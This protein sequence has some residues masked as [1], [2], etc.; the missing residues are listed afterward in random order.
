MTTI[1][2]RFLAGRYHA[3]PWGNH[4]NEGT[5]EW[6]PSPWRLLRGLAASWFQTV[7][8][9][10]GSAQDEAACGTLLARLSKPP[11]LCLPAVTHGHTRQ[12]MPWFKNWNKMKSDAKTLVFDSFRVFEP[13]ATLLIGWPDLELRNDE[14]SLLEQLL[15]GLSYLGRAESW[16]Q[17]ELVNG[18]PGGAMESAGGKR[19]MNAEA[20][21]NTSEFGLAPEWNA[22]PLSEEEPTPAGTES[23]R[24]LCWEA[25][26]SSPSL[27]DPGHPLL[28]DVGELRKR[29]LDPRCPPGGR[30]VRYATRKLQEM[31]APPVSGEY[32]NGRNAPCVARFSLHA[33]VLPRITDTVEVADLARDALQSLFGRLFDGR[34]S[35]TLSG[36]G[37]DRKP[38]E[39][40]AHAHYL[41][42]DE[43]GDGRIDTLTLVSTDGF[44]PEERRA[45]SELRTLVRRGDPHPI[46]ALLLGLGDLSNGGPLCAESLVWRSWTPFLLPRHPKRKGKDG[47][48]EQLGL[49]LERRGFPPPARVVG[50]ES[51]ER[52]GHKTRWLEFRRWR[53]RGSGPALALGFGFEIEFAQ[54]VRGPL[55][56]GYGSHYGLGLFGPVES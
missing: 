48:G 14:R 54:P 22:W 27:S 12:Y 11:H 36:K 34:S 41:P 7:R 52:G 35:R 44:G 32:W 42:A 3:T 47:P 25:G 15:A 8:R 55:A 9:E 45:F 10:G 29:K 28:V 30:W 17:A 51:H 23:V 38:L 26:S 50:L 46:D 2:L 31:P 1:C 33:Q 16:C 40:H 24:V 53:R 4:V 5:G 56:L 37:Q 49:E 43:D 39:G 19:G 18:P 20:T 6:P 21:V 13:G